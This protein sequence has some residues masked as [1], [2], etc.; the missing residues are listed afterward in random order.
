MNEFHDLEEKSEMSLGK[1]MNIIGIGN[2]IAVSLKRRT[3]G[4][5]E[6]IIYISLSAKF[7]LWQFYFKNNLLQLKP[8]NSKTAAR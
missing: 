2:C 8:V 5:L 6:K 1:P 4:H 7:S 3:D